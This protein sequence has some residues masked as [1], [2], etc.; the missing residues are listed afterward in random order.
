MDYFSLSATQNFFLALMAYLL[1]TPSE[2]FLT[3]Q[4][5][6]FSPP[7]L[8]LARY[9]QI[10]SEST[11]A[12][13]V[14]ST[15]T[16]VEAGSVATAGESSNVGVGVGVGGVG[17]S[18]AAAVAGGVEAP[19]PTATAGGGP[20]ASTAPA[21][22]SAMV[23]TQGGVRFTDAGGAAGDGSGA[24]GKPAQTES[25]MAKRKVSSSHANFRLVFQH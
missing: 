21:Q 6:P 1:P 7:Y 17:P 20:T 8:L 19:A 16:L 10:I 18:T 22:S 11:T 15:S 4:L 3:R 24:G 9:L 14:P 23:E 12:T 25:T 2:D 13:V 5:R